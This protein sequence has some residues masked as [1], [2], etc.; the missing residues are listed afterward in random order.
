MIVVLP[1][2]D[3][4][5]WVNQ[6]E[7]GPAWGDYVALDL[8]QHIDA[9]YRTLPMRGSRAVGGLS[10]GGAGALQLAFNHPAVFGLAGAHSPSLHQADSVVQPY[11]TG[12]DFVQRDPISLATRAPG[13]DGVR[14][15]I[16]AGLDDPWLT[17]DQRLD[18]VLRERGVDHEL[19]VLPGAHE[20]PYWQSHVALYVRMYD[21]GFRSR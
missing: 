10:M 21:A 12:S 1:Q 3:D 11:G 20:S 7:D 16:D 2:G 5:Y 15:W 17:Q 14:I 13:L 18:R 4:G 6:V 8:V 19:R 9:T